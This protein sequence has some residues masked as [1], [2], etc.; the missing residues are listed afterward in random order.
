MSEDTVD[1]RAWRQ[2]LA[3][4]PVH[5]IPPIGA[6][7]VLGRWHKDRASAKGYLFE[8]RVW[9]KSLL[10]HGRPK[11]FLMVGRPRS[12]T[13]LLRGLLNQVEGLHCD[14]EM[15]HHAVLAPH[16]FLNRLAGIKRA[17]AYGSK[18]LSYQIFEVQK[19]ADPARFIAG[20]V[21]DDYTLIHVRRDTFDQALSLSV[22]QAGMGYHLRAGATG[23][24]RRVTLDP[25]LFAAQIRHH[26]AMLDYEDLLFSQLPHLRVQ[27]EDDLRVAARHQA[28]VDRICTALELPSSPVQADTQRVSARREITN[29]DEL[30]AIAAQTPDPEIPDP[31]S[32]E[33]STP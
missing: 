9:A 30:R 6:P 8:A 11:R 14:G 24:T 13:T 1:G 17:R 4:H 25:D 12:G 32:K 3:R 21:T 5:G 20:L 19:I 16:A 15:L 23:E 2:A 10:R 28:T 29:I 33:R 27:Y 26:R 7:Y 18:L 22:A 31:E